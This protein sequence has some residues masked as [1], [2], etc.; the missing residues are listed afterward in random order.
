MKQ[1]TLVETLNEWN[2]SLSDLQFEQFSTFKDLLL[3]ANEKVN[4]TR[5]ERDNI[6]TLHF[7]DSLAL[8]LAQDFSTPCS[9]LDI[10][11]GA[12]FPAIP[13]AIAFPHLAIHVLDS[14]SKRLDFIEYVTR[15]IGISSITTLHGRAEDLAHAEHRESFDLV[16]ARALAP[17]PAL[18]E[19]V[20]PF[21]AVGGRS[22]LLRKDD[23]AEASSETQNKI[24]MLG[25]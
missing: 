10:G 6:D 16:T 7:L 9:L 8:S 14:S 11:S 22:I 12:G 13:L 23:E 24:E 18:V 20:L 21:V 5:V 3:H 4:L 19:L 1:S 2:L 25:G 15:E 17:L